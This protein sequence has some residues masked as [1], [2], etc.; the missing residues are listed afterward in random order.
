MSFCGLIPPY[1]GDVFAG[2][3][4][5]S[6]PAAKKGC[7][8]FS[9]DLNP[10]SVKAFRQNMSKNKVLLMFIWVDSI[11]SYSSVSTGWEGIYCQFIFAPKQV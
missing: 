7:M 3:G 10:E 4:P 2:V 5:F 11:F 1:L 6:I 8:V 9:N